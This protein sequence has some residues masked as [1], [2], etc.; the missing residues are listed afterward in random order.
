MIYISAIYQYEIS[1]EPIH[2]HLFKIR[3]VRFDITFGGSSE[4]ICSN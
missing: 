4:N 3:N 2:R 1:L